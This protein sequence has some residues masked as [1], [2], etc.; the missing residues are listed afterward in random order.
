M[1]CSQ[2]RKQESHQELCTLRE[3]I[4]LRKAELA[5]KFGDIEKSEQELAKN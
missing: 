5:V 4:S 2:T 1:L 3:Q